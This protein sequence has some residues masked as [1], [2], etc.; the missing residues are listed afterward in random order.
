MAE[1]QTLL[2][3]PTLNKHSVFMFALQAAEGTEATANFTSIPFSGTLDFNLQGNMEVFEQADGVKY[4]HHYY[5]AGAWFEGSVPLVLSPE[6]GA[7]ANLINWITYRDSTTNQGLFC[8]VWIVDDNM[9][10]GAIDVKVTEATISMRKGEP[11]TFGLTMRGKAPA[12]AA[13]APTPTTAGVG[14]PYLWSDGTVSTAN[15]GE[16]PTEDE[17]M[18]SL[19]IRIDNGVDDGAEGLRL[20]DSVY[21]IRLYNLNDM[22]VTGSF[23]RDYITGDSGSGADFYDAFVS[24]VENSFSTSG[25]AAITVALSRGETGLTLT[26]PRVKFTDVSQPLEGSHRGRVVQTVEFTA[27]ASPGSVDEWSAPITITASSGSGS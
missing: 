19:E 16:S 18:E 10:R 25:D 2:A 11:V 6:D 13:S 7:F 9:E 3:T 12:T 22:E 20:T 21:P 5:T 15:Y 17:N 23:E 27:I 26:M 24:Q 4:P 14:G 8:T 1:T